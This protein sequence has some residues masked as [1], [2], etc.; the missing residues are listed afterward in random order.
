VVTIPTI[1]D[2]QAVDSIPDLTKKVREV[3]A[4]IWVDRLA[5]EKRREA[6]NIEHF[7]RE[8]DLRLHQS[9]VDRASEALSRIRMSIPS[10]IRIA[11]DQAAAALRGHE[12]AIKFASLEHRLAKEMYDR[13]LSDSRKPGAFPLEKEEIESLM[14][15][16]V[17]KHSAHN[18]EIKRHVDLEERV[19]KTQAVVDA[20]LSKVR[21]TAFQSKKS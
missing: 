3:N 13:R 20:E 11:A 18:I 2:F 10:D 5:E 6:W 16:I 15:A 7:K 14:A 12:D 1:E 17:D 4:Q 21:R 9:R 8:G 19:K